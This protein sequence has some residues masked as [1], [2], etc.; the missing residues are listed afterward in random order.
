M[1]SFS[2]WRTKRERDPSVG[3]V[4]KKFITEDKLNKAEKENK[5]LNQFKNELDTNSE[6]DNLNES[7]THIIEILNDLDENRKSMNMDIALQAIQQQAQNKTLKQ[8]LATLNNSKY[9]IEEEEIENEELVLEIENESDYD[10][11]D[12]DGLEEDDENYIFNEYPDEK[13][14]LLLDYYEDYKDDEN[15]T[16]LMFQQFESWKNEKSDDEDDENYY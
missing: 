5:D 9:V 11:Y 6:I 14:N 10:D 16:E 3:R 1:D 8:K 13:D 4:H 7:K 12:V 2:Q 15:E